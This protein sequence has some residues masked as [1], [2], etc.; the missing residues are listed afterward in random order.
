MPGYD[1]RSPS[2]RPLSH[3]ELG[4][5]LGAD[6]DRRLL[7]DPTNRRIVDLGCGAGHSAVGLAKRGARVFATDPDVDQLQAAR[8][9]ATR[10]GVTVEFHQAGPAELA[11]L[12]AED[13]D[14][15]VSVWSLS[16]T[17]N[18]ERVVRQVHRVLR[19]GG[20]LLL[21]LPH[22][23][24]LCARSET[25]SAADIPWIA[26]QPVGERF[27]HPAEELVTILSRNKFVVD[28]LLERPGHGV[29]PE[30]LIV[31]GRRLGA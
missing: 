20:H 30:T 22:P 7:G 4:P 17:D 1:V 29:T 16:L 8:K 2:A 5:R 11:F 21:A 10:Q 19:T 31:R 28:A 26:G 23:A 25:P 24:A 15:V 6:L 3:V 9:L 14:L 13:V 12:R 18:L 27:V